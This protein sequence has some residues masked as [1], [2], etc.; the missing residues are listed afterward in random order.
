MNTC[1]DLS[2]ICEEGDVQ[3]VDRGFRGVAAEF[4]R[5]GYDVKMPGLLGKALRRFTTEEANETRLVTKCRW[6]I[7]SFHSRLKRWRMFCERIDQS[8]I[9]NIAVLA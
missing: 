9:L 4:E 6:I 8:F 7:E 2:K 1:D 3:I 5:M